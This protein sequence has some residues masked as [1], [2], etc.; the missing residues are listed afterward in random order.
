MKAAQFSRFGGPE[1]LEIVDLPEPHARAG[2]IRIRV[3][4]AGVNAS[5]WKKR[6]GEMDQD[7]PQ[8]MGYEAAGVVDELGEGVTDVRIGDDVFGFGGDGAAQ[9]EYAVLSAW[10]PIPR[11]LD[12]AG[13]AALPS[14][15]E[16]AARALD[17][18]G[19]AS[20]D[21]LLI[22]GASGS[23][24]SAAAQFAVER[25]ARVIGVGSPATHDHLRG[26]RAEPIAYGEGMP[27]R[28][29]AI[30]PAG[31][32]LAL[33]VAGNG[34][35]PE[36]IDLAGGAGNVITI[37]DYAGARVNGVR[38]SR[39]DSGRAVYALAL[40]AQLV[41]AGRFAVPVGATFALADVAEAHRIGESGRV[42]GKLVLLID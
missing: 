40:V 18:L 4:A 34:I 27:D 17:Q 29:R 15:V 8:T 13:A 38:F 42:R 11:S 37:A 10:C 21:T 19:V 28:V 9:A 5:D 39:G 33:D 2:E 36:L 31:V 14:T 41:D 23:I 25:G 32:D 12:F 6:L 20:G 22:N 7:L 3:R 35:L 24:G 16:T 30:A 1:V 26:L